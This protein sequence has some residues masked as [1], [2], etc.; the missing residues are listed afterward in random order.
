MLYPICPTCGSLLANIQI[1]Y[2]KDLHELCEKYNIDVESMSK[3]MNSNE[4][5]NKEKRAIV[6]KYTEQHRYCCRMR[7]T[8]FT[9]LVRLIN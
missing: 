8:N 5:F 7:L 4:E 1:P 6:D 9:D 3:S 2:Q